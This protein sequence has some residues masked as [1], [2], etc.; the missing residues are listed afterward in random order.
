MVSGDQTALNLKESSSDFVVEMSDRSE[1]SDAFNGA[2]PERPLSSRFRDSLSDNREPN[3]Y[4][5]NDF[6]MGLQFVIK[7]V[8]GRYNGLYPMLWGA[9]L[10]CYAVYFVIDTLL[11]YVCFFLLLAYTSLSEPLP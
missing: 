3:S 9:P 8:F 4:S 7:Y 2:P 11:S 10:F 1:G 6:P 5:T